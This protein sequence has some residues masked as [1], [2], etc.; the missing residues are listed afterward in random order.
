MKYLIYVSWLLVIGCGLSQ[1]SKE[2]ISSHKQLILNS[3]QEEH[4]NSELYKK[5]LLSKISVLKDYNDGRVIYTVNFE[6]G[7][8]KQYVAQ[9]YLMLDGKVKQKVE[10][11]NE[12][13]HPG[14]FRITDKLKDLKDGILYEILIPTG[15]VAHSTIQHEYFELKHDEISSLI[16][17][18]YREVDC[19]TD[20]KSGRLIER[21]ILQDSLGY[22]FKKAIYAFDCKDFDWRG[23]IKAISL[24]KEEM[25]R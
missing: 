13:Y 1:S 9:L 6:S 25:E 2:R 12:R 17:F 18:T 11:F 15:S 4:L 7:K 19:A 8:T 24:V 3:L 23:D 22:S 21:E 20:T 10:R 5:E 14:H 16:E